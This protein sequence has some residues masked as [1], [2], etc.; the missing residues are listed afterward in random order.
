MT[1]H[2][3]T[4]VVGAT[5]VLGAEIVRLLADSA[6]SVRAIVRDSTD[7]DKRRS[8]EGLNGVQT[9]RADLKDPASLERACHGVDCV[10]STATATLSRSTGD[11]IE[12]V[13]EGGQIALVAAAKRAG[14]R[15]FVFISFAPSPIDSALQRAKRRVERQLIQSGLTYAILQPSYFTEIWLSPLVGFELAEGRAR[16][17]GDGTRRVSWISFKDVARFAVAAAEHDRFSGCTLP[18]GGPDALSPLEVV[19]I[20]E[21]LGAP[22]FTLSHIPEDALETQRRSAGD[23]IQEAFAAL[24]LGIA[25]GQVIEHGAQL[26]MLSGS[27]IAVRHHARALISDKKEARS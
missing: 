16:V 8:I 17:F 9:V 11:S 10:I 15:R 25:G 23:P 4:L 27:L 2:Q 22:K 14:A 7:P 21:E 6:R 24:M 19:R 26:E 12:S 5:G 18:L 3:L 20:A 1:Q 13:D